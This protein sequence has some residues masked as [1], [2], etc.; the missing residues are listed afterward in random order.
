MENGRI[1]KRAREV[2]FCFLAVFAWGTVAHG[3]ALSNLTLSHDSMNEFFAG[4]PLH[5]FSMTVNEWKL[6]LGRFVE[7][8]YLMLF[9]GGI[10]AS[11]WSGILAL[12]WISLT[13][14][15]VVRLFRARSGLFCLLAAGILTVNLTVTA[16]TAAYLA[17][18]DAYLF[19]AFLSA[20]GAYFLCGG[21]RKRLLAVPCLIASMGIYQAMLSVCLVL[22]MADCILSFLCNE[23][24]K[25]TVMKGLISALLCIF[26]CGIYLLLAKAVL[27]VSGIAPAETYNGLD[28]LLDFSETSFLSALVTTYKEAAGQLLFT[29]SLW[30]KSVSVF[31]RCLI[32]L[33]DAALL[34]RAAVRHRTRA[35]NLIWILV[36]LILLPLAANVSCLLSGGKSH[37]LMYY[38]V[39]MM[40]LLPL[41]LLT[42]VRNK[43]LTVLCA[44]LTAVLL[45][46]GIQTANGLYVRK[47]MEQNAAV[48]TMTRVLDRLERTEG[49]VPGETEVVFLGVPAPA[50]IDA[51]ADTY[52]L[53]GS[54]K[55]SPISHEPYYESFFRY[56]L[57][58]EIRLCDEERRNE[59]R[60]LDGVSD[61]PVFPA[62]GSISWTDGSLTVKM[63]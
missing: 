41:L 33:T 47:Q 44:A 43:P 24:A 46:G 5:F 2:L 40:D 13:L 22:V 16:G 59:V 8:L 21:G 55:T 56:L 1:T 30:G 37:Q 32:L 9:K 54:S 45:L 35:A 12:T 49:Y 18:L 3:Y 14:C 27:R 51:F 57:P 58:T 42:D 28:R 25:E 38:A 52:R 48:S 20:L 31:L 62:E 23:S 34:L 36:C 39:W 50:K 53:T 26:S 61:L 60:A 4:G 11:W 29:V 63:Q 15:V 7:P 6:S 17:E 10:A 19:A